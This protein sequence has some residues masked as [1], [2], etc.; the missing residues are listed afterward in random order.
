MCICQCSIGP[1]RRDLTERFDNAHTIGGLHTNEREKLPSTNFF[2][3]FIFSGAMHVLSLLLLWKL[4][5]GCKY[6]HFDI[7]CTRRCACSVVICFSCFEKPK[8]IRVI[9]HLYKGVL[10]HVPYAVF[11]RIISPGECMVRLE[12]KERENNSIYSSIDGVLFVATDIPN[13][14]STI[15][16]HMWFNFLTFH[17]IPTSYFQYKTFSSMWCKQ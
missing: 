4:N 2:G 7:I 15:E 10:L 16:S 1:I 6:V 9:C 5:D 3:H 12:K 11:L 14:S 17:A 13:D 8:G